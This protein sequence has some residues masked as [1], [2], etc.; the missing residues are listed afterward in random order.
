VVQ[1]ISTDEKVNIFTRD[2]EREFIKS[3]KVTHV[4]GPP[5]VGKSTL[6]AVIAFELA[7]LGKKTIIISTERPIEIRMESMVEANERY[8]NDLLQNILTADILTIDEL[9]QTIEQGLENYIED[10]DLIIIDSLTSGYR[11]KAG[12]IMLTLLRKILSS[13]QSIAIN[14]NKAVMFTNQVAAKMDES[15]NFRPVASASTR[16]YSDITIRLNRKS[17]NSTEISFEDIN[18]EEEEVLDS[19]TITTAGIEDINFFLE[20]S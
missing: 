6:S 1:L 17:D 14:N 18:G 15:N 4:Y 7:L 3:G 2:S 12:P 16:T 20:I 5:K 19:F 11:T 10:I 8:S 9:I 13:L